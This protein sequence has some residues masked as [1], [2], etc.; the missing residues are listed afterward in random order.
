MKASFSKYPVDVIIC[1]A[2][3][4]FLV[5]F[6]FF[7]ISGALRVVLGLPFILFIPGYVLVFALF[8]SRKSDKGV[9]TVER[10]ALS[11]GLSIAVVPLLGLLLNYTPWGIRLEPI[12]FSL[13]LFI[14]GVGSFGVYRWFTLPSEERFIIAFSFSFPRSETRLDKALS[15]VLVTSLIIAG[16]LLVYVVVTPRQ[17]ERFTEFYVLGPGGKADEYP[18]V[19][20]F[21]ENATGFVGIVNHEQR[22]IDYTVEVWFL[23]QDTFF[24]QS[25]LENETVYL[26]MWFVDKIEVTLDHV[27]VDLETAWAPQ[28][29]HFFSYRIPEP[30]VG[31][32][33]FLL[34]TNQTD[35]YSVGEDYVVL[36]DEKIRDAYQDLHLWLRVTHT[37]FYLL[38]GDGMPETYTRDVSLGENVSGVVG[39]VNNEMRT[40]EY[41]LGIWLVNQTRVFD[42]D[43]QQDVTVIH[44]MWYLQ[45]VN[46]QLN[47]TEESLQWEQNYSIAMNRRGSYTMMFLLFTTPMIG[48]EEGDDYNDQASV[49]L[50]AAQMQLSIV[51]NVT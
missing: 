18:S 46:V 30:D 45:G 34:F 32:L 12:L 21:G 6:V 25:S 47:H 7:D 50:G 26:G 5:P 3:S 40:M 42:E 9:D 8:P 44:H 15:I 51:V 29:Q 4:I 22:T 49:L 27:S 43:L 33:M 23:K 16:V 39:I 35:E 14:F 24:N 13:I 28:W 41:T 11:F 20:A 2:L 17:G 38:D 1:M 37:R 36:A 10:I 31:K 48:F 19:L